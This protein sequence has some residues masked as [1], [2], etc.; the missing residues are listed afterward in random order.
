[1]TFEEW[2][3][4]VT[5]F[6]PHVWQTQLGMHVACCDQLLRIPTGFGKT[7][8]TV[9]SWAYHRALRKDAGWPMRLVFCL[10]MRVLVEQTESAIEGWFKE[11]D[12][13]IRVVTLLGG[14]REAGWLE[15]P[16][17]PVVVV[18]T[19]DMLL[20][21]ALSRGYG[22]SR[23]LWPMEMGMLHRDALWVV[24]EVQLMDVGLATTAQL[25]AFRRE[26]EQ[27]GCPSLRS[28]FTWWMSATLQP[29]WLQTVDFALQMAGA[30]IPITRIEGP[31]R[32]GGLWEVRKTCERRTDLGAP[33]DIAALANE[34][35]RPGTLSLVIV[36]TVERAKKVEA[37]LMKSKT[38]AE[39]RLV[40]SR[41]R[42][43]ERRAW[44]FLTRLK[45][46]VADSGAE[47]AAMGAE[48]R[49]V[50]ATQVVEAGVDISADLMIT[51]LAPWSSL[52]QRFGRCARYEGER[53]TVVV[54]GA[55]PADEKKALPYGLREL[56]AADDALARISRESA[57]VGPKALEA[58]EE[59]LAV[60]D[61]S[62]LANLYPYEPL[63]VLRRQDF[64]DL[65]DTTPDLSGA[66]L[67]VSRYIRS[68]EDR[69]V[70]VFWRHL[71][72][73]DDLAGVVPPARDELCPVPV[74]DLREFL[75]RAKRHGFV[76][77]YVTGAWKRAER[78]VPGMSV[79][80]A[81]DVGGY[82]LKRGWDPQVRAPVAPV[83]ASEVADSLEQTSASADNDELSVSQW[84]SIATHGRET[85]EIAFALTTLLEFPESLSRVFAI[86]G[87]WHDAGKAHDTFQRAI[88]EQV[89]ESAGES[90][91]RLDLAKAPSGAWQRPPYGNRPGFRH[92]LA[93]TLLLFEF[94]KRAKAEHPA[95]VA[96]HTELLTAIG[97]PIQPTK[98]EE[99]VLTHPLGEEI[100]SLSGDD[101]DL[102]A[103]LV[104]AHHGK[105]R[106][107][108]SSTPR[109]Q[110]AEHGGI[111]G[112]CDHDVVRE[113]PVAGEGRAR[114]TLP[115]MTLS[116]AC[117]SMGVNGRYGA[118]WGERVAG[119]VARFGPFSLAY[120]EAILRVADWRASQLPTPEDA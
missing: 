40:H 92:E 78:I 33:D 51:D 27:R 8:G 4:H 74:G 32:S 119:L 62:Y 13:D 113:F 72:S 63:H 100:A 104:C 38:K 108:W 47:T 34:R 93:S 7:A 23:G 6:R 54:V 36:N 87:R 43:A 102:L 86:A 15:N 30:P 77:D 66:D 22:S 79:L 115:T 3:T 60:S 64:D 96:S 95:L 89:R 41:F 61:A 44:T 111:H 58:F 71:E 56:T 48:G 55:V 90:G 53:G 17:R 118:S 35:H 49:I 28:T 10:P 18:G 83:A 1:M 75:K 107:S 112:V 50:V 73:D 116:L 31:L 114:H 57:H 91:R 9:L 67:D 65:F 99:R 45:A 24:D 19:Q 84:K 97:Q 39:V 29:A 109:D 82:D 85:A 14:R 59:R 81:A 11:A 37:A 21:R 25:H 2:F 68:G 70:S 80:L 12:L 101:F 88:K 98:D 16:D 46:S 26:D 103:Y 5:K 106:T 52:V 69:D 42:G 94:L 120:L 117:A 20:S 110:E 105:V 76:R